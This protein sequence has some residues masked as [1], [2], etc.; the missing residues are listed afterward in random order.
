MENDK[1]KTQLEKFVEEVVINIERRK[2]L[3]KK[4]TG[5]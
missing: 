2:E 5:L 4:L 1:I 3:L